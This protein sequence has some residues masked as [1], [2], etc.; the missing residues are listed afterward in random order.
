[1]KNIPFRLTAILALWL[2]LGGTALATTAPTQAPADPAPAPE[3]M[4]GDLLFQGTISPQSAAIKLATGSRYTHCAIVLEKDGQ[5]QVFEAISKIGWTTIEQWT[6]RGVDGHYVLMRLKDASVLTPQALAAMRRDTANYYNKDYD[7]LF[8]WS[9]D[10]QYCSELVWKIY[11]R[12]AG[13]ELGKL[14]GFAD[15][16][17]DSE[18]VRRIIRQRYGT[19]L[20]TGEKVIAPSD[21][22]ASDLLEVVYQN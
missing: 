8:Q 12:N 6:R 1:M 15:Y 10:K 14:K 7:L 2:I 13:L 9:D 3:F 5:L 18:E 19:D 4:E 22:M 11:Q 20:P 21:L 17:L 16:R